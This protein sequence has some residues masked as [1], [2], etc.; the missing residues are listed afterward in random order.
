MARKIV[1]KRNEPDLSER[2]IAWRRVALARG[3]GAAMVFLAAWLTLALA[4]HSISDPSLNTATPA[5]VSNAAGALGAIVSDVLLQ[6]FGGASMILIAPLAIWGAAAIVRGTPEEETPQDVRLRA[7]LFPVALLAGAAGAAALPTPVAWPFATGVGGLVGEA[8]FSALAGLI[9]AVNIP[10]AGVVASA[11]FFATSLAAFLVVCGL[12][13]ERFSDAARTCSFVAGAMRQFI[14]ERIAEIERPDEEEL[15]T[16]EEDDEETLWDDAEAEEEEYEYEE[17]EEEEPPLVADDRRRNIIRKNPKKKASKREAREIQPELPVF[18]P[19][20][21][22]LPPLNLL[23]KPKAENRKTVS[24]EALEQNA[25]MLENVLSDFG[26][27][28]EII[29]VRPG[30]V[31]TLYELE[32]AAGVKSS[33]VIG[34]ADDIARSMSAVAARVAVVPGRNAIGIELPNPERETVFLRETLES[35]PYGDA[36]FPLAL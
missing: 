23:A 28:G 5:S 34:L 15:G 27:R 11:A 32:P 19:G 21:Y 18:D 8:L 4:T 1:R 30:P 29:N 25:R 36:R 22:E 14:N 10:V 33:R 3:G 2:F 17:D 31:V 26:V 24:D 7:A 16:L 13:E 12:T 35:R 20:T 9:A 6:L